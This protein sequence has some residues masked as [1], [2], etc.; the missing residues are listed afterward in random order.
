MLVVPYL[1]LNCIYLVFFFFLQKALRV[2][3]YG[4][5]AFKAERQ[6]CISH[7]DA[8]NGLAASTVGIVAVKRTVGRDADNGLAA[9]TVGS[10]PVKRTV[11]SVAV[12]R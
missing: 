1:C 5:E 8:D 9:S 7:R 10:V 2:I 4:L 6:I 3:M 12:K 11:G